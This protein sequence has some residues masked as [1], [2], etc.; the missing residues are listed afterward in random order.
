MGNCVQPIDKYDSKVSGPE[1]LA[2]KPVPP[3]FNAFGEV[4]PNQP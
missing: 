2:P 4:L 1:S 3:I